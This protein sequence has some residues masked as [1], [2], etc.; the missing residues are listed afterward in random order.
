MERFPLHILSTFLYTH[1]IPLYTPWSRQPHTLVHTMVKT[2]TY[3][4]A[5]SSNHIPLY[6]QYHMADLH[7]AGGLPILMKELLDAGLL[8]GDCLTVTGKTVAENLSSVSKASDL[9]QDV[10]YP[11][12]KPLSPPGHHI[13]IIKVRWISCVYSHLYMQS[14]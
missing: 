4:C 6:P 3:H 1:H 8:H 7:T 13:T 10:V 2:T 5:H 12:S 9:T 11:I 14:L